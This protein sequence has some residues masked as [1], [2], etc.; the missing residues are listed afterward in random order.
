MNEKTEETLMTGQQ[1]EQRKST[2]SWIQRLGALRDGFLVLAASS[3]VMGYLV[4]S[5]NAWQNNLGL[6]PALESQYFVAGI[7][8]LSFVGL[9]VLLFRAERRFRRWYST[10]L[11]PEEIERLKWKARLRQGIALS[12]AVVPFILALLAFLQRWIP[13]L[14][15]SPIYLGW[16]LALLLFFLPDSELK[17]IEWFFKLWQRLLVYYVIIALT[18]LGIAFHLELV[19]PNIPQEFGGVRPRCAYLDISQ[20][21][22]AEETLE[23]IL[24]GYA[25]D[26]DQ[27]IVQSK[28][29]D[30]YF[31]GRDFILVKPHD[32]GPT[33]RTLEIKQSV[34]LA[35]TWCE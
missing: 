3:Y 23:Q 24:P 12:F 2:F 5:V 32:Q 14:E 6:L 15:S 8:P 34:V 21:Q 33:Q 10:W 28:K 25:L 22:V 29:V 19:Y 11:G 7:I 30:V 31:S 4:W 9:A 13:V 18:V 16:F 27:Q 20:K 26:S 17:G 35:I 1:D